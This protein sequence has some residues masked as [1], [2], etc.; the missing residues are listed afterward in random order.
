MFQNSKIK[1]SKN[2][3]KM[4]KYSTLRNFKA[5]LGKYQKLFSVLFSSKV[6]ITWRAKSRLYCCI[7]PI[8]LIAPAYRRYKPTNMIPTAPGYRRYIGDVFVASVK[9]DSIVPAIKT[10]R[11]SCSPWINFTFG[12]SN[13][14]I[15]PFSAILHMFQVGKSILAYFFYIWS[16]LSLSKQTNKQWTTS[17]YLQRD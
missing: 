15:R 3:D 8:A 5:Y 10:I 4:E 7:N 2:T 14:K 6:K 16:D 1:I 9:N 17:Q 13:I 11:Q 12:I